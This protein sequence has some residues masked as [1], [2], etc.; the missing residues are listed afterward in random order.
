MM[1]GYSRESVLNMA[2]LMD[3]SG[4]ELSATQ[5]KI[6]ASFYKIMLGDIQ[7]IMT[8][9]KDVIS[10]LFFLS[11]LYLKRSVK[12][13]RKNF[14]SIADTILIP[15]FNRAL[16]EQTSVATSL[17]RPSEVPVIQVLSAEAIGKNDLV[18][19]IA[20]LMMI[21]N[22]DFQ[23]SIVSTDKS[24]YYIGSKGLFLNKT[25]V[26]LEDII[27]ASNNYDT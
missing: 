9:K 5:Q 2:V 24:K 23:D 16:Y 7:D 8:H 14:I 19:V 22:S 18:K 6:T 20:L 21:E 13:E 17:H 12:H 25:F 15:M 4:L 11:L 3:S 27:D 1:V 26:S 10:V